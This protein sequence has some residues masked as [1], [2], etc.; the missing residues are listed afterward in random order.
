MAVKEKV[1][2]PESVLEIIDSI[3]ELD[4]KEALFD[5]AIEYQNQ[6]NSDFSESKRDIVFNNLRK[7]ET[8]PN[9]FEAIIHI[10]NLVI[11]SKS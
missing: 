9:V 6:F 11:K 5:W 3:S 4:K 1:A 8:D 7:F 2:L 10:Q